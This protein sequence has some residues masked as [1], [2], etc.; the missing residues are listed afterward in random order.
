MTISKE[1]ENDLPECSWVCVRKGKEI[2]VVRKPAAHIHR[3]TVHCG[4][5]WSICRW[6]C[7]YRK[8]GKCTAEYPS[9]R[10]CSAVSH[11]MN[12]LKALM[13]RDSIQAQKEKQLHLTY[14]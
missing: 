3:V 13:L 10:G 6:M 4:Q 1:I 14:V 12:E 8:C 2:C 5:M 7:G 9:K 11:G